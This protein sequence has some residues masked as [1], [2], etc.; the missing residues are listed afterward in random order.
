MKH[1]TSLSSLAAVG[2]A[3]VLLAAPVRAMLIS[4][5]TAGYDSA[6]FQ[7]SWVEPNSFLAMA[8][9]PGEAAFV[10]HS[11]LLSVP[12][13]GATAPILG[14]ALGGLGAL[15]RRFVRTLCQDQPPHSPVSA[16]PAS[17][18]VVTPK[19]HRR[20]SVTTPMRPLMNSEKRI[21]RYSARIA[22]GRRLHHWR[23]RHH[24]KISDVAD[25][26][27][28]S[29]TAWRRWETGEHLPSEDLLHAIEDLTGMPL[30]VLFC[31]H[32]ET[33]PLAMT[34]QSPTANG[35]CCQC[36]FPPPG[37]DNGS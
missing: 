32:L 11:P 10:P 8:D 22:L 26:L 20:Q 36:A 2:L 7:A 1:I 15:R 3:A 25:R 14:M 23:L 13:D 34:G 33:C 9:L 4:I 16:S 17:P 37:T 18:V 24:H 30:Y 27:G 12:D 35:P 19:A 5:D 28:I 21:H 6:G 31:P 29:S